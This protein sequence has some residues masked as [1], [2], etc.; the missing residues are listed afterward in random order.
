MIMNE[1]TSILIIYTGGTIGM[2]ADDET[3]ALIPFDFDN[4][5]NQIPE[6]DKFNF[7]IGF[8]CFD[9][10]LDSS[11][12]RPEVWIELAQIIQKNY[13]DY[14]GFVVLHGSDTMAY[15][16]SALS[17]LLENLSKPV[18]FTGSQL[19]LGVLRTDGRE[20]LITAIEI[21]ADKDDETPMVPEVCIYFENHLMR[22]NRTTKYNAEHF[23][24]FV[25]GNLPV[26]ADIGIN[27]K[28]ND[29]IILKPK[30]KKL[31]AHKIM[32]AN[33]AV[34]PL[35]PGIKKEFVEAFF[36]IE[37]LKAVVMESYGSGNAPS[38]DWFINAVK[39][40]INSGM[41]ILNVTQ[42]LS[43]AVAHGKYAT[44]VLLEKAGVI[45]GR[46]IT[47]EAALT[48]LMYLLG[49]EFDA[50]DICDLLGRPLRGEMS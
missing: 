39:N 46:D 1:E 7:N 14:D 27:I 36:N 22:A 19:P 30:F 2:I 12:M 42:C 38:E 41:I 17:F 47:V 49:R 6:L 44:S 10:L 11:N 26:L 16:A 31:K 13:E 24:A 23:N 15:S 37:G 43:G 32:D 4:I 50:A 45:S 40:A 20:N 9:P 35:F 48:K 5:Y 3:G 8:H 25:S 33:V 28:Y 34:L 29:N 18:I 21:A